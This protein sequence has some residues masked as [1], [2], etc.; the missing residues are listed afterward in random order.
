MP[1]TSLLLCAPP[2]GIHELSYIQCPL[3]VNRIITS[4]STYQQSLSLLLLSL[5]CS[6]GHKK[7]PSN[8]AMI[9]AVENDTKKI[10]KKYLKT[11]FPL[12]N[13]VIIRI[14][15]VNHLPKK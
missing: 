4:T 6:S 5:F 12:F 11:N 10:A 2:G 3:L 14:F 1:Q 8:Q 9:K 7:L 13:F 15:F